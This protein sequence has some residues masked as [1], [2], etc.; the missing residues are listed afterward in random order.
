MVNLNSKD[1]LTEFMSH[2]CGG[3]GAFLHMKKI[4]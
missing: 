1:T 4:H 3:M 2:G